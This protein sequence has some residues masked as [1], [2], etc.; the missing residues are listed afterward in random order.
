MFTKYDPRAKVMQSICHN[1][2]A[3][4]GALNNELF[5]LASQLE[6]IALNDEYFVAQ[7]ISKR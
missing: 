7:F 5:Q 6:E 4:T 1:I 3:H 2:L